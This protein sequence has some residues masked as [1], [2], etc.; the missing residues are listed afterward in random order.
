M[1]AV[2]AVLTALHR[3]SGTGRGAF[4]DVSMADGIVSW[5]SIH[6]AQFFATK[7]VPERERMPLSGAYPC[8]RV[9]P[10]ADGWLSVGALEPQFYAE[11]L[12]R[13]GTERE[14]AEQ[15]DR[16][17]WPDAKARLAA[18]FRT[19]TRDEWCQ[20][21]EATETCFA[22][23]LTPVE[24]PHHPHNQARATFLEV[25]GVPQPAPAPRFSRT[26]A[27]IGGP[28]THP[29]EDTER[30]LVAWG[31]KGDEIAALRREGAVA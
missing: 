8:Y 4:C 11:L 24:A 5:L 1:S 20:L 25:D 23:V 26:S 10:A 19:K 17:R 22:P 30:A 21:L 16:E 27:E 6:A 12:R 14:L 15:W 28:P 29:G 2:I 31:F 7:Q 3:R 13:T 18:V 9:Y